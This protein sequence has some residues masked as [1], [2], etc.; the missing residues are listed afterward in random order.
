MSS[1]ADQYLG[2][3]CVLTP[4]ETSTPNAR[5]SRSSVRR[6]TALAII[7][8]T[9]LPVTPSRVM[10][11]VVPSQDRTFPIRAGQAQQSEEGGGDHPEAAE[12]FREVPD[13][14][15]SMNLP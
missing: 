1:V 2:D 11:A 7:T 9:D 15:G 13:R 12:E 8:L 5:Q 14:S 3:S 6:V 10:R 4:C